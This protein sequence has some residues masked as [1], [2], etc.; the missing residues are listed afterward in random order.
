M[1][2]SRYL[3][4]NVWCFFC[5]TNL[6]IG[7]LGESCRKKSG[8]EMLSQNCF[9]SLQPAP[10]NRHEKKYFGNVKKWNLRVARL[11]YWSTKYS[12]AGVHCSPRVSNFSM[13]FHGGSW[14][15]HARLAG[16]KSMH[17]FATVIIV[18][19]GSQLILVSDDRQQL[20]PFSVSCFVVPK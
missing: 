11:R 18:K 12:F 4:R 17:F 5:A 1:V 7:A 13:Q 15:F 3:S 16:H 8:M 2:K 19:F 10:K 9:S 6:N 14:N 20:R